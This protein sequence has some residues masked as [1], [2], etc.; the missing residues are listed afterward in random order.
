MA[1]ERR[2]SGEWQ[3]LDPEV[4]ETT[5]TPQREGNFRDIFETGLWTQHLQDQGNRA[6]TVQG[7][8]FFFGGSTPRPSEEVLRTDDEEEGK[9]L[10]GH[11]GYVCALPKTMKLEENGTLR[12]SMESLKDV[13]KDG[14]A[15][16]ANRRGFAALVGRRVPAIFMSVGRPKDKRFGASDAFLGIYE[17]QEVDAENL[18]CRLVPSSSPSGAITEA[19]A[20]QELG[21]ALEL[22]RGAKR[23]RR[24]I[25][26][27]SCA[28][29]NMGPAGSMAMTGA[30][31]RDLWVES[32]Q[33]ATM[34][35]RVNAFCISDPDVLE[36]IRK[37]A[38]LGR[39]LSV[40]LRCDAKQQAKTLQ[41]LF[42][43]ERYR[44][45]LVHPVV[46]SEDDRL[47]MHKK[48]LIIDAELESGF[49]VVG[50]YNPTVN[51]RGSQESVFVLRDKEVVQALAV[52]FD[53]D[54]A[55][56]ERNRARE[57]RVSSLALARSRTASSMALEDGEACADLASAAA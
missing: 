14:K 41:G 13:L 48:E 47:I 55:N 38:S 28:G 32:L 8:R 25:P 15:W 54:W 6:A 33:S 23:R 34:S 12:V 49:A 39:G 36:E 51:A 3:C 7:V 29:G 40:S 56:E 57:L 27:Y 18:V 50:S 45:V 24:E 42:E 11:H 35:V 52:R 26:V 17:L 4:S 37:A 5:A 30:H 46:V 43:E 10:R 19:A 2:A 53:S 20:R 16:E 9:L 44:H 22:R 21:T 31:C 1:W